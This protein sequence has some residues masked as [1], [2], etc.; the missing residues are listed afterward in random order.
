MK[1]MTCRQ[2][3]GACDEEFQADNFEEMADLSRAHGTKMAEQK[4]V[5]HLAAME[6]MQ[7]I[8]KEP[9]GLQK[10]MAERK[11]DFEASL[12]NV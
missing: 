4:D 12:D 11:A 8:M 3:G 7:K 6:N 5:D 2:L 9:G 1:T 10:W